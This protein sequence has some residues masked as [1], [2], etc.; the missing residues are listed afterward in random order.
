MLDGKPFART[1]LSSDTVHGGARLAFV[2]GAQPNKSWASG[3]EA[4]P[5]GL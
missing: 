5:P 4:A 3:P 1:W 2:T